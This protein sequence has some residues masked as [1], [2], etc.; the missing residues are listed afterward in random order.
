MFFPLRTPFLSF[1]KFVRLLLI[2]C[3]ADIVKGQFVRY[4]YP[5]SNS[6]N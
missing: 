5:F 6:E 2:V 1:D 4:L 3:F